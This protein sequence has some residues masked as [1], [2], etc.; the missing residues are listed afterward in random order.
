MM[1]K[2]FYIGS[3]AIVLLCVACNPKK[4]KE[5]QELL[6]ERDSLQRELSINAD[7]VAELMSAIGEIE[8]N[9]AK[10]KE[11][12]NYLSNRA[13]ESGGF[14]K[15]TKERINENFQL[16]NEILEK[17]RN[18]LSKLSKQLA[19]SKGETSALKRTIERL[20]NELFERQQTVESLQKTIQEKEAQI[21]TLH[22]GNQA[23]TQD[24]KD[25]AQ[26][27]QQ[28]ATQISKQDK[29]LHTGYFV[30]GTSRELKE[31][32]II[33]GGFLSSTKVLKGAFDKDYF[34]Q[35][36]IRELKEL[37]LFDKKA[38]VLSNHPEGSYEFIKDADQ[39]LVLKIKDYKQFWSLSQYLVIQVK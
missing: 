22:E 18:E 39:N 8:D 10:I 38:K 36:D 2:I 24:V 12:E 25:L 9:F 17:N 3:M 4:S 11:A 30:F 32:Q 1:K 34:V 29:E 28:Q 26:E 14:S 21:A 15:S 35:V 27:N 6:S 5:F 23:L 19:N 33:S 7:E 16:M 13:L 37:P 31:K 20:N